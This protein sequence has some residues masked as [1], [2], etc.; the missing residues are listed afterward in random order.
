MATRPEVLSDIALLRQ[1]LRRAG[2]PH[3]PLLTLQLWRPVR[4]VAVDLATIVAVL[5]MALLEPWTSPLVLLILGNRQRAL[6]NILHDAA[7]RN[8]TRDR[9][10]NDL[11]ARAL[12]A[13]LLF[14][15]LSHYRDLHFRHHFDL[16]A[17]GT[18][19]DLIPI[20]LEKARSWTIAVAANALSVRAVL[21][22]TFGHLLDRAV[23][24]AE[25]LYI[26]AW[27]AT[28]VVAVAA[29]TGE[30]PAAAMLTLWLAARATSFHLITTF[31]EMCDHHGLA[32]GGVFSFTR[33]ITASGAWSLLIHPRNNAYHLTHHLLPAVPYY[34]LPEAQRLFAQLPEY[35]SRARVCPAYF[36][37]Q[38]RTVQAWQREPSR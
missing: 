35:Q 38:T 28:L 8:L 14:L 13:P 12:I 15:S 17:H 37:G 6:G 33:D 3:L 26:V 21:G 36:I 29:I 34:R 11:V 27:W 7:H 25:R 30:G 2:S 18:D 9:Q 1:S 31:R 10:V 5:S 19:P 22:S 32:P 20:P 24:R 23:P 4:D 16:G